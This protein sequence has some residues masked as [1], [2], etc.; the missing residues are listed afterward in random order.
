MTQSQ[1]WNILIAKG[2]GSRGSW[3]TGNRKRQGDRV[4]KEGET[5]RWRKVRKRRRRRDEECQVRRQ[6]TR[7]RDVKDTEEFKKYKDVERRRRRRR[8]SRMNGNKNNNGEV[9]RTTHK[10]THTHTQGDFCTNSDLLKTD[11]LN[12]ADTGRRLWVSPPFHWPIEPAIDFGL[13]Q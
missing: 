10:D 8:R 6:T 2:R 5:G 13:I 1:S 3:Q 12:G 7:E 9:L 11:R 4:L